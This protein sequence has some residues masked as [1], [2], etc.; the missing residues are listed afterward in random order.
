MMVWLKNSTWPKVLLTLLV[1]YSAGWIT[2]Y[3][4]LWPY[5]QTKILKQ[6]FFGGFYQSPNSVHGRNTQFQLLA[7][8]AE[9]VLVGDSLTEQGLWHEMFPN[10]HIANRGISGDNSTQ[11]LKRIRTIHLVGAQKAFLMFGINDIM[12]G[13]NADE[14]FSNYRRIVESLRSKGT[15]VVI[16]S[17]VECSVRYCG[18]QV[19]EVRKLNGLLQAYA[20]SVKLPFVNLNALMSTS[21][22]GLKENLTFDGV[23]LNGYG[24]QIWK[25]LMAEHI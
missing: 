23:H 8:H 7:T 24:Y 15:S 11:I 22:K 2:V 1:G 13:R 17:N 18:E 5:E 14:V 16:Q 3:K 20:D 9:V 10:A 4:H 21:E 19:S 6:K 12:Q 25:E